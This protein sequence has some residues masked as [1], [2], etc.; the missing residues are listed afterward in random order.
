MDYRVKI[1]TH[2]DGSK[3]FYPQYSAP[4]LF[5]GVKWCDFFTDCYGELSIERFDTM[6][7]AI[8]Y[9]EYEKTR[10][11]AKEQAKLARIVV[12]TEYQSV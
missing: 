5:G 3:M 8:Q 1:N 2:A 12:T 4:R 9:I 10:H 11:L 7:K 6:D